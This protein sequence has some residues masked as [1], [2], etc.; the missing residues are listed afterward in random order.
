SSSFTIGQ[1]LLLP[2]PILEQRVLA[3]PRVQIYPCG[4]T[5]IQT[6]QIDRRV[7]ATLEFLADSGLNPTVTAL[8]CGHSYL[9]SSGNVSE[10]VTGDA[11]DIGAINGTSILGHQGSGSIAETTVKRLMQLQGTMSPHQ[12]ISLMDFGANTLALPDHYNHIH[13][14]FHPLFG[15]NSKL[16]QQTA[17][18]LKP[19]QWDALVQHLGQITNP[20][21]PTKPSKFALPD[22]SH[23]PGA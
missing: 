9:T 21:V 6:G 23:G 5:D 2:K 8:K 16:G 19:G 22:I 11:V 20:A 7:L 14:G 17:S 4:R 15:L 10:H 12:I 1:V 13:V 18:I 3:D